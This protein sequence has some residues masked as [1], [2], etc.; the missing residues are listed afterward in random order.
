MGGW[1][2]SVLLKDSPYLI[3]SNIRMGSSQGDESSETGRVLRDHLSL[4]K[5]DV[6]LFCLKHFA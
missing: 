3:T 5:V 4:I 1:I 2:K 6:N